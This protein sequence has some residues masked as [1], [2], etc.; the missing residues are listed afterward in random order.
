M[1]LKLNKQNATFMFGLHYMAN[2]TM[3]QLS[4]CL[5]YLSWSRW[6]FC[7]K[8][9]TLI[10]QCHLKNTLN[11]QDCENKMPK[12]TAKCHHKVDF[13]SIID[14]EDFG[15]VQDFGCQVG[16]RCHI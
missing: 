14:E 15:R 2:Y 9:Y 7:A 11:S 12:D 5:T 16:K 3:Q 10:S 1:K 8:K 6:N 13:C 4:L